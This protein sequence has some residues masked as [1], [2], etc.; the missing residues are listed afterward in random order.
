MR[1]RP[2][3]VQYLGQS[4]QPAIDIS[5]SFNELAGSYRTAAYGLW[6]RH[7]L[8]GYGATVFELVKQAGHDPFELD[9]IIRGGPN[10]YDGLP[11]L[12]RRFCTRSEGLK[13]HGTMSVVELIALLAASSIRIKIQD[14]IDPGL[15]RFSKQLQARVGRTSRSS[16][17][18]PWGCCSSSSAST[19]TPF[20]VTRDGE[21][22]SI[23]LLTRPGLRFYSRSSV[24]SGR[25]TQA[26]RWAS[27]SIGRRT[28]V[29]DFP[30]PK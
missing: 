23:T 2:R 7:S 29:A 30:T 13:I 17:R 26:A 6:S 24:R 15:E 9:G 14:A 21:R 1:L 22:R 25:S 16:S 28:C 10:A 8:V 20:R 5:Y 18:P 11:D 27:S 4:G 19:C 3:Y 12:V